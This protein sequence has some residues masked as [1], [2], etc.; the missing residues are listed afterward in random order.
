[1]YRELSMIYSFKVDKPV[2]SM[3]C[4]TYGR[5]DNSLIVV[6]GQVSADLSQLTINYFQ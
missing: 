2:T 5:E 4:G 1:M 3:I 6:H